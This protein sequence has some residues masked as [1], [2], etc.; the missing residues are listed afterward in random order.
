MSTHIMLLY[1]SP[2]K[3]PGPCVVRLEQTGLGGMTFVTSV[4]IAV[5]YPEKTTHIDLVA[6]NYE[7][8]M[9]MMKDDS[10]SG[11]YSLVPRPL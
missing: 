4:Y 1:H 10:D 9:I 7:T 2:A 6:L 5:T 8:I 3:R 11:D